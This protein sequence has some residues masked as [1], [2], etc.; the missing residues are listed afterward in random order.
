MA[1]AQVSPLDAAPADIRDEVERL[2]GPVHPHPESPRLRSCGRSRGTRGEGALDAHESR[3]HAAFSVLEAPYPARAAER[4]ETGQE[5]MPMGESRVDYPGY[6]HPQYVSSLQPGFGQALRLKN[7]GGWVM[8]REIPGSAH[9]DATGPYP[10]FH[11]RDWGALPE[12]LAALRKRGLVS[13]VLVSDP[14]LSAREREVFQ[15]FDL[16]KPFK[17]HYLLALDEAPERSVSRH[18]RA[19]VRRAARKLDVDVAQT[20]LEHLDE[21]CALYANLVKRRGIRDLRVFSRQSFRRLLK[22]PG[23]TLFR[24]LSKGRAVGAQLI[25]RQGDVAFAHLAAFSDEGYRAGASY[26]LD[27]AAMNHLRGRVGCL[28]WGGAAGPEGAEPGGLARYKQGWASGSGTSYLLGAVL[29]RD[30]YDGLGRGA[31]GQED[32]FFPRYR[33]GEFG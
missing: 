15:H 3:T 1:S 28:N 5:K 27:W 32:A 9:A 4:P 13:L 6:R 29:N 16:V 2:H 7:S 12:D 8:E 10:L 33:S 17:T 26:L 31:G 25:L 11:C 22:T 14:M 19:C 30:I 18:H 21:W 23:M 24:A 20:P